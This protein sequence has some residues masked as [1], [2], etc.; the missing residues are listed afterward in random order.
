MNIANVINFL[1]LPIG[2]IDSDSSGYLDQPEVFLGVEQYC[3][4]RGLSFDSRVISQLWRQVDDNV[5]GVLD[6]H[7]FAVFLA[8]YCDAIG[9]PLDDLAFVVLEQ[10]TG[11]QKK[12]G[13]DPVA[14]EER[15]L[16]PWEK[17]KAL[18][19]KEPKKRKSWAELIMLSEQVSTKPVSSGSR[20]LWKT[21]LAIRRVGNP[22]KCDADET[23]WDKLITGVLSRKEQRGKAGDAKR[24]GNKNL[25][26]PF[27][28]K[29]RRKSDIQLPKKLK[30]KS[31]DGVV[32]EATLQSMNERYS[33]SSRTDFTSSTSDS[34]LLECSLSPEE[35]QGLR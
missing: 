35:F 1:F 30:I 17:L 29:P 8:R 32:G 18:A 10:L 9:V 15:S 4:A 33:M 24:A 28:V 26:P 16:Y 6:R 27:E 21:K 19:R 12:E 14:N 20:E 22:K 11:M 5:D 34:E 3:E 25:L 7:E 31:L 2:L 13:S 23:L